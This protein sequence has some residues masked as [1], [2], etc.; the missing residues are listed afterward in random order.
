[1][2]E[3]I[4]ELIERYENRSKTLNDMG[5]SAS[6]DTNRVRYVT[7]RNVYRQVVDELKQIL[8]DEQDQA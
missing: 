7:K 2:K 4:E 3:A 5:M 8:K 1:M 6:S